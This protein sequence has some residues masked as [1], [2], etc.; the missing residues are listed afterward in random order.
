MKFKSKAQIEK[1]KQL[2][3][4]GKMTQEEFASHLSE[5]VHPVHL[6]DRVQPRKKAKPWVP[7]F[8]KVI[9]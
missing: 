1:F 3:K 7:R 4:D 5:S 2:V 9:K 8:A 6:P